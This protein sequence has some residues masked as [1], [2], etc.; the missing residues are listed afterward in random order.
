MISTDL[1]IGLIRWPTAL[2]LRQ[3]IMRVT[4]ISQPRCCLLGRQVSLRSISPP[5]FCGF[6]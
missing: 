5:A 4:Q 1:C 3:G 6:W 2:L